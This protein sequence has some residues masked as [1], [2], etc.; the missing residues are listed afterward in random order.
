MTP[1][2]T[3]PHTDKKHDYIEVSTGV[4]IRDDIYIRDYAP[5]L[6]ACSTISINPVVIVLSSPN[7]KKIRL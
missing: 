5:L 7:S 3:N 2:K 6:E 1:K 4:F